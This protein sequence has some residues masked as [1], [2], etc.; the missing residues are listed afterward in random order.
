MNFHIEII[1]DTSISTKVVYRTIV[2]E[3][4]P[5]RAKIKAG[6]LLNLYAGRGA[7]SARVLGS[8]EPRTFQIVSRLQSVGPPASL[9]SSP[10]SS[11]GS[12]IFIEP[13]L[14]APASRQR[15]LARYTRSGVSAK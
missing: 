6:A 9:W 2:D 13:R 3:M 1:R 4:S 15:T 11:S 12:L 7:N 8:Q 5:Q 10:R 14:R